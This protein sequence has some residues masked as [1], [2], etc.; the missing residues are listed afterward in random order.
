MAPTEEKGKYEKS[1]E[2]NLD[3]IQG[4]LRLCAV[5][6]VFCAQPETIKVFREWVKNMKI[7][8]EQE[9]INPHVLG[10]ASVVTLDHS[11]AGDQ[12]RKLVKVLDGL[13]SRSS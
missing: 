12:V 10:Q 11:S 5:A 7:Y 4:S 8:P 6:A 13:L 3:L 1:V 9:W 2:D